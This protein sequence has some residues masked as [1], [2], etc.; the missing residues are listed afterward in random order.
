MKDKLWNNR[1]AALVEFAIV[2]LL[3][4][5]LVFGI[6]EYS[7]IMKDQMALDNATREGARSAALGGS[8]ADVTNAITDSAVTLVSSNLNNIQVSYR[9]C[10]NGEWPT[11]WIS[12]V[13]PTAEASQDVQVMVSAN[14]THTM[15]T[16]KMFGAGSMTLSSQ[17]VMGGY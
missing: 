12:G 16:G 4:I 5:T 6:V 2:A 10:S 1:G 8:S 13:V 3:L 11:S 14:Y 9:V 17:I 7:L 15:V